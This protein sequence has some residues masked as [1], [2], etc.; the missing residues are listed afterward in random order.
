M[1][2][3][4]DLLGDKIVGKNGDK[5]VAELV[6]EG[7]VV[8]LYFS[9][10]WCPP[11]RAFTPQLAEWY[12]K[13][14]DGEK[15]SKFDIVFVSSDRDQG[16]FDEY[17]N[18][19][20]W[21]ALPFAEREKKVSTLCSLLNLSAHVSFLGCYFKQIQGIGHSYLSYSRFPDGK[22][23]HQGWSFHCNG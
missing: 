2:A 3:L 1:S 14:K 5:D 23:H 8:A 16:S 21:L 19:M 20:P 9:A 7:K 12:K 22:T 10:H 13:F 4:K 6:G 17:Y 18:D 11:C 15:G